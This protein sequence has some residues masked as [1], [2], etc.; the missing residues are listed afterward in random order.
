MITGFWISQAIYAAAK[1]GIADLVKDGP[2]PCE[3]LAQATGMPSRTL[4]R[5]LQALA[6]VGVFRE[7]E[8]GRFGLTSLA[9]YL[10]SGVPGSLR[11]FAIMQ[12]EFGSCRDTSNIGH[13]TTDRKLW[14]FDTEKVTTRPTQNRWP[15][16]GRGQQVFGHPVSY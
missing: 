6:S 14:F 12:S 4:Y 10:Q 1:L 13:G 5:L 7:E 11:A 16:G 8:D 9:E 3:E 15:S 2:K